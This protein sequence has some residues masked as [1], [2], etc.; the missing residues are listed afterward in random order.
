LGAKPSPES[1]VMEKLV[2]TFP[3]RLVR[4]PI[5]YKLVKEHGLMV[6]ILRALIAPDEQGH[7]VLELSGPRVGLDSGKKYLKGIGVRVEPL[8][9]DV[10]WAEERCTHCTACV[11]VCPSRALDVE[12]ATMLVR[13]EAEKCIG[14]GL[15]I[16]VCAY[17]AMAIK[18]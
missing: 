18:V 4:E 3:S 16:P 6:N 7:M 8:I 1:A 10:S 14:C 2:L 12:R 17:R 5:T 11:S 9:R 15:C 13:F